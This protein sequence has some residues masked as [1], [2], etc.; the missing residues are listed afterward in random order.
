MMI[1][2][3]LFV[4]PIG[5]ACFKSEQALL[6]AINETEKTIRFHYIPISTIETIRAD[7][8]RRGFSSTDLN[9][10]NALATATYNALCDYHALSLFGNKKARH[11]LFRLQSEINGNHQLYNK[12]LVYR[13]L[14]EMHINH[15]VFETSRQS[16][17]TKEA[18]DADFNLATELVVKTTPTTIVF[19]YEH[20][21]GQGILVEGIMDPSSLLQIFNDDLYQPFN[22]SKNGGNNGGSQ[23][24]LLS[25]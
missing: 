25:N 20:N 9:V 10:H 11:Y 3:F 5:V 21:D 19:D 15:E 22:R 16:K 2:I 24:K 13:L 14:D 23:L 12:E 18:I 1:E 4:N 6:T 17:Y 8:L 7:V